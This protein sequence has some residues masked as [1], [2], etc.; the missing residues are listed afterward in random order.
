MHVKYDLNP[1][2][3]NPL[4]SNKTDIVS[5]TTDFAGKIKLANLIPNTYYYYQVW[6][7]SVNDKNNISLP[8]V[9][10]HFQ[11]A[12]DSKQQKEI[13]SFAVGGDLGGQKYC[14][15][16]ELGYPVFSVIRNLSPDFFIFNGDQIYADGTCPAKGPDNV[17]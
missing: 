15:R 10:G 11:T 12:P 16:T 3:T 14:Q 6:F 17:T 13:I 9:I 4:V 5:N 8:S 1:N 2:F 7:S